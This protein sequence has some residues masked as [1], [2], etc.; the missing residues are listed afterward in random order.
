MQLKQIQGKPIKDPFRRAFGSAVQWYD[1]LKVTVRRS[2]EN[3]IQK[4]HDNISQPVKSTV[5]EFPDIET[6][7]TPD[8]PSY[9]KPSSTEAARLLQKRCPACF[10]GR[11]KGRSF[12]SALSHVLH[13]T[14]Q[15]LSY[16]SAVVTAMWQLIVISTIGT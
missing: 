2:I 9:H 5:P 12:L 16:I 7:S 15:S 3:T 10:G 1:C 4:A 14:F 11:M 13:Q 6:S 8:A